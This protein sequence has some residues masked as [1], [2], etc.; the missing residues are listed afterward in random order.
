M[1]TT[2]N[3]LKQVKQDILLS[4]RMRTHPLIKRTKV[5]LPLRFAS[6]L[7]GGVISVTG[8]NDLIEQVENAMNLPYRDFKG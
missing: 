4:A 3:P 7:R 5:I 6:A 2:A 8:I 1:Q